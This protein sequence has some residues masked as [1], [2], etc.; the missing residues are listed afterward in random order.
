MTDQELLACKKVTVAVAAAY[1]QNGTT[2]QEIRVKAQHGIC[3]FCRAEKMKSRY[4]YR[5]I[6]G[7][8]IKHKSD[9]L[10]NT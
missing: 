9:T 8:L 1:L 10:Q 4:V 7:A 2:A 3:P 5:V 6:V